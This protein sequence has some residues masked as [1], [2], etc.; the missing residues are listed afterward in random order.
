MAGKLASQLEERG[1]LY[2]E[3]QGCLQ[4]GY[5]YKHSWNVVGYPIVPVRKLSYSFGQ[6]HRRG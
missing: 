4:R 2:Q 1:D 6:G 5:D 3:V